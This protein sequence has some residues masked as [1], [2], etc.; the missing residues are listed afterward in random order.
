LGILQAIEFQS[1]V[2]ASRTLNIFN[3]GDGASDFRFEVD[4]ESIM[5]LDLFPE[6][7]DLAPDEDL[8]FSLG[9]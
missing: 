8:N 2:G 9:D 5:K 3:D 4:G 1:Q 6:D 7:F